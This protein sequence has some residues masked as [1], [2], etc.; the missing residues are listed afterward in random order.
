MADEAEKTADKQQPARLLLVV[1]KKKKQDRAVQ[2]VSLWALF[3]AFIAA[4]SLAAVYAT[5]ELLSWLFGEPYEVTGRDLLGSA[6]ELELGYISCSALQAAPAA[7]ALLLAGGH[8]RRKTRRALAYVA[9]AVSVAGHCMFASEVGGI[10]LTDDPAAAGLPG[11]LFLRICYAANIFVFAAG[12]LL[13]FLV[14]ALLR[15]EVRRSRV[16]NKDY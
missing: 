6:L 2:F 7:L 10:L 3:N 11:G 1:L 8:R 5:P 14:L 15:G 12:D 4:V 9:L 16:R 13:C